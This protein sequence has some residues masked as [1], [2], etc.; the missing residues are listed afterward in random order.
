MTAT[1]QA[2]YLRTLANARLPLTERSAAP[3]GNRSLGLIYDQLLVCC[4][5]CSCATGGTGPALSPSSGVSVSEPCEVA[6]LLET[7]LRCGA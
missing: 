2:V 7:R 6:S 1:E 3:D 4:M 5:P